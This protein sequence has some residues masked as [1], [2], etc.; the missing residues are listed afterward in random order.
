[1]SDELSLFDDPDVRPAQPA[2]MTDSQRLA[3]RS[4]FARLGIST[5]REQFDVVEKLTGERI[6]AVSDLTETAAQS[7]IYGLQSKVRHAGRA[8]T[9]NS[10]ADRDEDTWIDKL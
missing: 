3:I 10:W 2:P 4:A 7:L 8:N 1:M 5:A 6:A 9:G